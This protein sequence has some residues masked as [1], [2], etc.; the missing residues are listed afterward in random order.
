MATF[1]IPHSRI[2]LA[3]LQ[4]VCKVLNLIK[5]E[6][7]NEVVEG[8]QESKVCFT[9]ESEEKDFYEFLD[10]LRDNPAKTDQEITHR[11]ETGED[12]GSRPMEND[13]T[14]TLATPDGNSDLQRV[15]ENDLV[16]Q[17]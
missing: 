3:Y 2:Y 10:W 12:F 15:D 14:P 6:W 9:V 1:S 13:L 17:A 5:V 4:E 11:W 7:S 16:P 8:E